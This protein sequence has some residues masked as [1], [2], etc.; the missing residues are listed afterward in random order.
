MGGS[1]LERPRGQ[2][3]I[4]ESWFS[5]EESW[6]SIRNPDFLLKNVELQ[7]NTVDFIIQPSQKTRSTSEES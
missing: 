4:E 6:F 2:F 5:I 7:L 1:G 3:S